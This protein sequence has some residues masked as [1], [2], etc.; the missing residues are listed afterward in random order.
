MMFWEPYKTGLNSNN[1][2]KIPL[3]GFFCVFLEISLL[4][5][6]QTMENNRNNRKTMKNTNLGNY[7]LAIK[8]FHDFSIL[9]KFVVIIAT[10]V[11]LMDV[12]IIFEIFAI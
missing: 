2:I 8:K 11:H 6:L 7:L 9:A 1:L 10:L 12:F 4:Y 3:S 5:C